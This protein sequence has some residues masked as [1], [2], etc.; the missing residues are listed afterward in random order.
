MTVY[1]HMQKND[2]F[3]CNLDGHL[4]KLGRVYQT[5]VFS[6]FY[7]F[8]V[9]SCA[10]PCVDFKNGKCETFSTNFLLKGK[11]LS[12][13]VKKNMT[14]GNFSFQSMLI[15]YQTTFER[16]WISFG[17]RKSKNCQQLRLKAGSLYTTLSYF[18]MKT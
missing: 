4:Q 5:N 11:T 1:V 9:R 10:L 14:F 6:N 2:Q 18:L 12:I 17:D 13:N 8:L 7:I 15:N 3:T 16:K